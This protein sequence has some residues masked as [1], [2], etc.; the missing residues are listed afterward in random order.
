L[1]TY[2]IWANDI[3]P[4]GKLRRTLGDMYFAEIRPFEEIFREGQSMAGG[5]QQGGQMQ[6]LAQLQK[7]KSLTPRGH[8]SAAKRRPW[9]R[10]LMKIQTTQKLIGILTALFCAAPLLAQERSARP[11]ASG[12]HSRRP[13]HPARPENRRRLFIR[14]RGG[15]RRS[16]TGPG[17]G[18]QACRRRV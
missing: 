15:A 17:T 2:F 12:R 3:G 1:L 10:P 9:R 13:R 4:D 8:S 18:A 16:G 7:N 11:A 6:K 5:Q 14:H